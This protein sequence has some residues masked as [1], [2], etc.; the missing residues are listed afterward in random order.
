LKAHRAQLAAEQIAYNYRAG[1]P[2]IIDARTLHS[3]TPNISDKWRVVV[4]FI[5]DSF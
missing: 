5:Y 2:M 1:Q 3:V 4:W